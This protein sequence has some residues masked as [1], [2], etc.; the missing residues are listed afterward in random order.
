MASVKCCPVPS[1]DSKYNQVVNFISG[2]NGQHH[3][4]CL[5]RRDNGA[6]RRG[7][8]SQFVGSEGQGFQVHVSTNIISDFKMF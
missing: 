2:R 3:M 5:E 4:Y 7:W 8:K 1:G 6:G